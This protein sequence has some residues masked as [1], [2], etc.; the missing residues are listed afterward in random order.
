[1]RP[2]QHKKKRSAQYKKKHGIQKDT[3]SKEKGKRER[4]KVD[5]HDEEA[6]EQ[7]SE[8]LTRT[9]RNHVVGE[10]NNAANGEQ[11]NVNR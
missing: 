7:N 6:K 4:S 9:Q 5:E 3:T 11:V 2:D 8:A 1:M 10:Q